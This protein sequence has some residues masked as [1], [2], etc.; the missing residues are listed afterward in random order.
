[1]SELTGGHDIEKE[2]LAKVTGVAHI[3]GG[4]Q[5]SKL[6]RMLEPSGLG[7]EIADPITPPEIMLKMQELRGFDDKIAYGKWHM[8][9]G[10]VITTPEPEKVLEAAEAR[11]VVAKEIGQVTEKPSIRVRNRGVRQDSRWLDFAPH[12]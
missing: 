5:P 2:P 9:P 1:M 10:M 7:V 3:T 4:G 11:G 8:G 12:S 6:G